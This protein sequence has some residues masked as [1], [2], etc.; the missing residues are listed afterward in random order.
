MSRKLQDNVRINVVGQGNNLCLP[1]KP[2]ATVMMELSN[3]RNV[4]R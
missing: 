3:R 4:V 1:I 2:S